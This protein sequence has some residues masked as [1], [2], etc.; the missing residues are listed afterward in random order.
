MVYRTLKHHEVSNF[1][2][3]VTPKDTIELL[4]NSGGVNFDEISEKDTKS[5]KK[6][7]YYVQKKLHKLKNEMLMNPTQPVNYIIQGV[8]KC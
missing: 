8:F 3:D 1:D 2:A 7:L 5:V 4:R 6:K